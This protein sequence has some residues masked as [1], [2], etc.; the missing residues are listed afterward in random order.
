MCSAQDVQ[1]Y[2]R[3]LL[4]YHIQLRTQ[5]K[6]QYGN[7]EGIQKRLKIKTKL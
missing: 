7:L 5:L 3:S 2:P 6:E 4:E 1:H